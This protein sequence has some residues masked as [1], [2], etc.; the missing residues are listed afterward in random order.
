MLR[1][2]LLLAPILILSA[3]G[4]SAVTS[5]RPTGDACT[6]EVVGNDVTF[7]RDTQH[8]YGFSLPPPSNWQ[9]ECIEEEGRLLR[10]EHE[11]Q[12]ASVSITFDATPSQDSE[13]TYLRSFMRNVRSILGRRGMQLTQPRIQT[14]DGVSIGVMEIRTREEGQTSLHI[15]AFSVLHTSAGTWQR[16]MVSLPST[17]RYGHGDDDPMVRRAVATASSFGML[18]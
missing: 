1:S 8:G 18:E 16:M 17:G 6:V 13:I 10:G 14:I 5:Q 15:A 12:D 9:L 4:G 3:C 2:P 7:V 11:D